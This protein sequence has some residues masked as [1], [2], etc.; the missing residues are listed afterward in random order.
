MQD[1]PPPEIPPGYDPLSQERPSGFQQLLGYRITVWRPDYAE[2]ELA[3]SAKLRN[4]SGRI[5][6]G[7]FATM[8]DAIAGHAGCF[9]PYPG[10]VRKAVTL[11][12]TTN[13]VGQPKGSTL[14]ATARKRGG[15][16]AVF[17]ADAEVRDEL[18]TLLATG[19]GTFRYRSG[20][21]TPEGQ[22]I[23]PAAGDPGS[24]RSG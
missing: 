2:M 13:Y 7:V 11:S 3:V 20:S 23:D 17:F 8:I 22:P 18:G 6:G 21:R 1:R 15:G 16:N 10:R 12:L 5:H 14:I 19:V 4:R 24:P 9:C